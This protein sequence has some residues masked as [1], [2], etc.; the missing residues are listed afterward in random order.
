[1]AKLGPKPKHVRRHSAGARLLNRELSALALNQRVL[2]L[3]ADPEQPLLE[4]VRYCSIGSNVL[5]E[6][7]MIRVAVWGAQIR[8]YVTKPSICR[9]DR[10]YAPHKVAGSKS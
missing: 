3:A 1:V 2:D 10:V 5:D 8:S 6:F 7:F 9:Q 4:R